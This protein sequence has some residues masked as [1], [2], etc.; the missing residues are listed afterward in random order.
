MVHFETTKGNYQELAAFMIIVM[1]YMAIILIQKPPAT[2]YLMT[3]T[4]KSAIF[5]VASDTAE[6]CSGAIA[7]SVDSP[8]A[9]TS[10]LET[11]VALGV[12]RDPLCGNGVCETPQEFKAMRL[13]DTVTSTTTTAIPPVTT[14]T[15]TANW[16]GC[17]NE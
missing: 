16:I 4:V 6:T 14:T 3:S 12:F 7:P 1:V 15:T 5:T 2:A 13:G 9:I 11:S 10:W 17:Q 8:A